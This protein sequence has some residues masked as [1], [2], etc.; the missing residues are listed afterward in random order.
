V[1]QI[2]VKI[3]PGPSRTSH[4]E[5]ERIRNFN[6]PGFKSPE[7][8]PDLIEAA[9]Q[10]MGI[11]TDDLSRS[12][13][14]DD[15]LKVE[16]S[17]PDKPELT[18]VDLP[19]LYRAKSQEQGAEGIPIVRKL[20]EKYMSNSR[21]IILA[22]ISAR[23]E[24]NLQEILDVAEK[25]DPRHERT[26]GIIT[27]P[28]T[29]QQHSEEEE[30]YIEYASNERKQ[31]KLGWHTLR[32]RGSDQ[33]SSTDEERDETEREFFNTGRWASVARDC[34]GIEPL[35]HRLSKV[36]L[37][38]IQSHLPG[39]VAE[40]EEKT[41]DRQ[42]KLS[43]LGDERSTLRQQRRYLLEKSRIFEKVVG[44]AIN[45]MYMDDFF[46]G[47]YA[48]N[49]PDVLRLRAKIRDLNQAFSKTM[50]V[51]G[52]RRRILE[53]DEE[54]IMSGS[55]T[56]N[57]Y[58]EPEEDTHDEGSDEESRTVTTYEDVDEEN[59]DGIEYALLP[60]GED[61]IER[62]MITRAD[63]EIEIK[64]KARRNRGIELP[65]NANQLL[66]G[67]L[68]RDQSK[69][70]EG[71]AKKHLL[72]VWQSIRRFVELLLKH[73]TDEAMYSAILRHVIDSKLDDMKS[74]VLKKL[75][76]LTSYNKRGHPLPLDGPFLAATQRLKAERAAKN[77]EDTL[78]DMFP[79]AFTPEGR[80]RLTKTD[81]LAAV[82]ASQESTDSFAANNVID[83]MQTY[84]DVS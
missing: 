75:D 39:L 69:P 40:I 61:Q 2:Q 5:R 73:L 71:I 48:T 54:W 59:E 15:I 36:L 58:E 78:S 56:D 53:K 83:L 49:A 22:I 72:I 27:K 26:L 1:S 9:Q 12:G 41:Q 50:R 20:V 19:G 47:L 55:E 66:V 38:H 63:L 23:N 84:Y 80:K 30:A 45:G 74:D 21:S 37:T 62:E 6:P 28:D 52:A 65:G 46:G 17:G 11:T 76:E 10:H 18:L 81:V 4:E 16:I 31:L 34:V 77:L 64:D 44:L 25:H 8:L 7:D 51:R 82:K 68:F 24:Y 43:K 42:A 33:R 57:A 79:D 3:E 67:E 32:N 29:L 70:W 35:R 13:F 60:D 14:S